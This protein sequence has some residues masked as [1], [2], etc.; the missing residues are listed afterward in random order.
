VTPLFS[1]LVPVSACCL[2]DSHTLISHDAVMGL[3]ASY[4][5][6]SEF[7]G[8]AWNGMG[9]VGPGVLRRKINATDS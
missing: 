1:C 3:A 2:L 5:Q 7:G 6:K 8:M 9:V 4:G